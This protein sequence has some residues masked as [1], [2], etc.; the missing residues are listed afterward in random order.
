MVLK[1]ILTAAAAATAALTIAGA[2][3][4]GILDDVKKKGHLQCGVNTGLTGFSAP[5]DKGKWEGFD[6]D[7]CRAMSAAIFGDADK[8]KYTPL[9]S[10]ERF[11]ALQSGEID[12]LARNTTWTFTRDVNLGLEFIG[13]NYVDGQGF[14]VR[15]D[16]GVKSAKELDG[17]SVCIQTGTTTEL[18]L[19]DF[20]RSNNMKFKSVVFEKADEI[21]A[22]YDAGR[23]D[24][25]TTDRSGL[26]AQRSLLKKPDDHVVLP[27]VVSKEPLGP[28][29]RHG[30]SEWGDV[31]RWTLFALIVAEELG[32]TSANV[33][34]MK[35]SKNPEVLRLLGVEGKMGEQLGVRQDWAYQI[36]KSVGNY[37]EIY[38]RHV[39]VNTPLKLERGLNAQWTKGG[40]LY[41]PPVR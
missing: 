15:K 40:L 9:T 18:N 30:Q 33:D 10:K 28:V 23:C 38:E 31:A 41:A 32:V 11:T 6:V 4:A 1:S 13:N 16:L 17:A 8:V 26:A 5:N 36:V 24:V 3:N 34:Q 2:A 12:V 21:R 35:S 39:G 25:Y 22:A 14:M 27:E 7:F 19:A 29:V 20:F 37:G